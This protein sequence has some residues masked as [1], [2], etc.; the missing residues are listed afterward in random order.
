M[1]VYIYAFIL[2]S[3]CKVFHQILQKGRDFKDSKF[4]KTFTELEKLR[5]RYILAASDW[6]NRWGQV[7]RISLQEANMAQKV[8]G[9]QAVFIP[10]PMELPAL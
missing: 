6:K 3:K 1:Y 8:I 5:K 4:L 10:P 9:N 2:A 7:T